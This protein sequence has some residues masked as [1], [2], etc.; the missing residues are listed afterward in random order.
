MKLYEISSAL[1]SV[2]DYAEDFAE[3]NGGEITDSMSDLIDQ[4]EM[5]LS[6]KQEAII[7]LIKESESTEAAIDKELAR[8]INL[9]KRSKSR[10][11]SLTTYL[12][13]TVPEC[14]IKCPT[15]SATWRKSEAVDITD[16]SALPDDFKRIKTTCE[17]DKLAIK[18]AIKSGENIT[19]A[20]IKINYNLQIK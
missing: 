19:G 8:L 13:E 10:I 12:S 11:V 16:M 4:F 5:E 15:W 2:I 7:H 1:R 6:I 3:E 20:S 17:P 14:G 9:K 18:S